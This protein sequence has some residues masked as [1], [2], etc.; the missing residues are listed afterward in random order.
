MRNGA[1][2]YRLLASSSVTFLDV[3]KVCKVV[4]RRI[5]PV[6]ILKVLVNTWVVVADH[7]N[8]AT[9]D[10]VV[11]RIEASKRRIES[12]VGLAQTDLG[13]EKLASI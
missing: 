13:Y 2:W 7:T 10:G 8:V 1:L 12:N 6:E 4:E 5:V 11:R 3:I 9:K